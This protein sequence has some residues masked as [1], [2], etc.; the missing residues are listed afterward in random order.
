M[1]IRVYRMEIQSVIWYFRPSFVNSCPF[2]LLSGS[3]PPPPPPTDSVLLGGGG[4]CPVGDHIYRSHTPCIC[5]DQIQNI[6]NIQTTPNENLG[7]EGASD[8]YTP[9]AKPLYRSIFLYDDI[10]FLA[11]I[12]LQFVFP[13]VFL[14]L[15]TKTFLTRRHDIFLPFMVFLC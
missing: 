14:I 3:T 2:N 4:G 1:F 9:A 12:H 8:R 7:G 11:S 15:Q 5:P 10:L 6:Q 13:W